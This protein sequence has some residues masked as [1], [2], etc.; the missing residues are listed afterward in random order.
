M[1]GGEPPSPRA[2]TGLPGAR[3]VDGATVHDIGGSMGS[4]GCDLRVPS[5]SISFPQVGAVNGRTRDITGM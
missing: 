3:D 1:L 4:R 5:R 2:L